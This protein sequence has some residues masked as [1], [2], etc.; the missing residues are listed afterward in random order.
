MLKNKDFGLT[1]I[2]FDNGKTQLKEHWLHIEFATGN[3]NA[4]FGNDL[5]RATQ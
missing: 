3:H 5:N 1:C 4:E 2:H